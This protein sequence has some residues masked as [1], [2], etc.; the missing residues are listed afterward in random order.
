ASQALC[1]VARRRERRQQA[2]ELRHLLLHARERL[3]PG[4]VGAREPGL[5]LVALVALQRAGREEEEQVLALVGRHASSLPSRSARS[6]L[7]SESSPWRMRVF[8][9]PSGSPS[10]SAISRCDRPSKKL[11]STA[12]RDA[13][14][15]SR[16]ARSIA[17]RCSATSAPSYGVGSSGA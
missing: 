11:S 1:D 12:R 3:A 14:G 16:S 8:T 7:R 6:T 10:R 9:V 15:S 5:D 2:R 4:R 17:A 13:S